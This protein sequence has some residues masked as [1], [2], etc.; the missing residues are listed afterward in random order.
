VK[1]KVPAVSERSLDLGRTILDH[2]D[3]IGERQARVFVTPRDG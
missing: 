2:H 1:V 3:G